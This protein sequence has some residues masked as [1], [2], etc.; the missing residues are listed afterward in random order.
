MAVR[1]SDIHITKAGQRHLLRGASNS[2]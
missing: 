1:K 2:Y